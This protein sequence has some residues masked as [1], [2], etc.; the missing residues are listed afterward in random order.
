[1]IGIHPIH[2]RL[3]ALTFKSESKPL[4]EAEKVELFQCLK[5]NAQI[6]YQLDKYKSLSYLAHETG[7][8]DWEMDL[9]ARIEA[10]ENRLK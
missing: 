6:V 4:T 5:V 2:R 7:D 9:C 1:M 8:F 10:I 3:A